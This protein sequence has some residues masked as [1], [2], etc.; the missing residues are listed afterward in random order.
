MSRL[1]AFAALAAAIVALMAR[2]Y[3]LIG[4]DYRYFIPRLI[5]TDLHLR[6]NGLVV[7]WYT[8]TFGGGLPAFPNP[9]HLQYSV[10]Q[11]LTLIVN[12]WWA[13]L[14]T[15]ALVTLAG[16]FVT[17]ALLRRTLGLESA[18]AVLGALFFVGNG[19]FIE[20]LIVGHLGFQLFPLGAVML[21]A[22]VDRRNPVAANA[23]I[24]ALTVALMIHQAGFYL[25]ILLALSVALTLP[26][27]ALWR[28]D[29]V[30]IRRVASTAGIALLC[31]AAMTGSK[32]YATL[33]LMRQFPREAF[34][35]YNVNLLQGLAGFAAQLAGAMV[36]VP[37]FAIAQLDVSRVSPALMKLTGADVRVGIWEL[38]TGLSPVLIACLCVVAVKLLGQARAHGLSRLDR[39]QKVALGLVVAGTWIAIEATLARG[40]VYPHLKQLPIL[41]A[42]HVNHRLAAVFVLPLSIAGAIAFDAWFRRIRSR[43]TEVAVTLLVLVAPVSYFFLP[44]RV[45]LRTFDVSRS[46]EAYQSDRS[47]D[48][49]AIDRIIDADDGE[50]LAAHASSFRPYE[51]LFGYVNETFAPLTHPGDVHEERD[52]YFNMTNPASLVF[53]ADN[54]V[55]PFERLRSSERDALDRLVSRRQPD[56]VLPRTVVWLNWLAAAALAATTLI[57]AVSKRIHGRQPR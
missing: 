19:F 45:H 13:V 40:L 6:I 1:P 23:G 30:T 44:A 48:R 8:P 15:T 36:L 2:D 34:D 38:D 35:V 20:H 51:P 33:A 47:G 52:G 26:A 11:L 17:Y 39:S 24:L 3:P 54:H 42:L 32:V 27:L 53:P 9:Q 43:A 5:D 21:F 16:C 57:V 56:F 7:Q 25:V 46:I 18:A 10:V 22:L 31:A 55:A 28:P 4:H 41:N 29:L 37:L 14:A 12:P 50:A 49:F